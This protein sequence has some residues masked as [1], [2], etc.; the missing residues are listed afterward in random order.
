[1]NSSTAIPHI[2]AAAIACV[3]FPD[4]AQKSTASWLDVEMSGPLL[5]VMYA[6]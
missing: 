2:I 3:R 1:M 4:S 6:K 5:I